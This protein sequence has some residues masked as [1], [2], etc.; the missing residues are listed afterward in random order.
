MTHTGVILY[1][2]NWRVAAADDTSR[3]FSVTCVLRLPDKV[4]VNREA[5]STITFLSLRENHIGDEG[6]IAL[7]AALTATLVMC[8][9]RV[10]ATCSS[11]IDSLSV[12][13]YISHL[14]FWSCHF[15]VS[16]QRCVEVY[17]S[18]SR[19]SVCSGPASPK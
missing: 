19:G 7:A 14:V 4:L 6:A 18:T 8:F 13:S 5:N 1:C 9:S 17:A 3:S 12:A 2:V 10:H 15:C 16:G 11:V